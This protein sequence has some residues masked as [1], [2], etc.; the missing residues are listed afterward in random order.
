VEEV[1]RMLIAVALASTL[2]AAPALAHE[3]GHRAFGV[4]KEV[5]SSRIV[6]TDEHG[7]DTA[8]AV[9]PATKFLRDAKPTEREKL[10]PGERVVVKGKDSSGQMEAVTVN[11]GAGPKHDH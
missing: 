10:A 5:T 1:M 8:F 6:V 7:K 2:F 11:V 9:T 3:G 4:L